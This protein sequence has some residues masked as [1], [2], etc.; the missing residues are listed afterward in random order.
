MYNINLLG[1]V[2]WQIPSEHL[3]GDLSNAAQDSIYTRLSMRN[4]GEYFYFIFIDNLIAV[5]FTLRWI[6][7][8]LLYIT[9]EKLSAS[10]KLLNALSN[11]NARQLLVRFVVDEA[12]CVSQ[13]GHD[14]RYLKGSFII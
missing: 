6:D 2:C 11:L 1:T 5:L 13:W 12:H 3:S 8:K 4:P 10:T 9:P 7:I 14:F